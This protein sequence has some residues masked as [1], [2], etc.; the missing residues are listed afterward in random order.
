MVAVG[1]DGKEEKLLSCV[2]GSAGEG[3]LFDR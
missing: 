1:D 2:D 3:K